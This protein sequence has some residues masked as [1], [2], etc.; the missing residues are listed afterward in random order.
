MPVTQHMKNKSCPWLHRNFAVTLAYMEPCLNEQNKKAQIFNF[1]S[2]KDLKV[3]DQGTSRFDIQLNLLPVS[4]ISLFSVLSPSRK[5]HQSQS[6]EVAHTFNFSTQEAETGKSLCSQDHH[7]LH[8]KFQARQTYSVRPC[9]KRRWGTNFI[10]ED[11]LLM[12]LP[13]EVIHFKCCHTGDQGL[14]CEFN[15][16][17]NIQYVVGGPWSPGIGTAIYWL[18]NPVSTLAK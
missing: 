11:K 13:Q 10:N 9:L 4:Q 8:N 18:W 1:Y 15:R 14:M 6:G 3:Q 5:G 2:S 7:S 17:I 12:T 16:D